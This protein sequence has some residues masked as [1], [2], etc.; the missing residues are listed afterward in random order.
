MS[1]LYT[2]SQGVRSWRERLAEPTLHWKRGASAMELAIAWELAARTPRGL[3]ESV[4]RVIDAH[5]ATKDASLLFGFPEHQVQLAGG[6]RPSQTDLWAVLRSDSGLVSL[7]VEGKAREP[8]GPTIDEW[9]RDATAGKRV[10]L[11]A[12]RETLGVESLESSELR[13]QLFHRAASAVLEAC[14]IGAQTA[15]LLVQSFHPA[16]TAWADFQGFGSHVRRCDSVSR[17][18]LRGSVSH[19]GSA[20]P[21]VGGLAGR[22]ER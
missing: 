15:V 14:R 1:R 16:S 11:A 8:F 22:H 7:A 12:L 9:L 21:R 13:Y 10:R 17:R 19:C 5:P 18:H 3:P 20:A 2:P 6:S 4:A